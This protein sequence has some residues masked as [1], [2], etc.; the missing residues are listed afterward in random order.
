MAMDHTNLKEKIN[1]GLQK[2][3]TNEFLP[4]KPKQQRIL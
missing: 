1:T 3:G 2:H 4:K